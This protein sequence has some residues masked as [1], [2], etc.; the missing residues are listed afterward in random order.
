M[1]E[2]DFFWKKIFLPLR[3]REKGPNIVFLKEIY[4]VNYSLIFLSE[5]NTRTYLTNNL[6]KGMLWK[7]SLS[8]SEFVL[9]WMF[10]LFAMVLSHI[11]NKSSPWHVSRSAL[12]T[13]DCRILKSTI[14]SEQSDEM[15][16]FFAWWYKVMKKNSWKSLKKT[17]WKV[18]GLS[19][20]K[21]DLAPQFTGL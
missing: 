1:V 16:W 15:A 10:I 7:Y 13:L 8:L 20:S 4:G 9:Q 18:F 2:L 5:K 21:M 12:D 11:W 14:S 3:N 19:W 6:I 17:L